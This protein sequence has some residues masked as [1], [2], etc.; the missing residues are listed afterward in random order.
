MQ[1]NVLNTLQLYKSRMFSDLV[2]TNKLS[3]SLMTRPHEISTIVSYLFGAYD[4]AGT[5]IDFLTGG[6]GKTI[7]IQNREFEWPV[8]IEADK[9]ITIRRA[10]VNG[11]EVSDANYATIF[12]GLNNTPI[13]L[14]LEEKWFGPGAILIFDD[15]SFKVRVAGEPEQDGN[16]FVYT[17]FMQDAQP[18]SYVPGHLLLPSRQVSREGTAYE[19]YSEEADI[20]NYSTPFKLRNCTTISRLTW[21]ITGDAYS[22]VMTIAMKDPK[23]GKTSFLW[24]PYQEWQGMRQW[25]CTLEKQMLYGLYN[26]NA[27]GTTN[28][29]GT[30][31]RPVFTGAG[32]L[33]Q[34]S[35]ANRR[36]YTML[37]AELLEDFL[38]DLSY[39]ILG[40]DNRKFV[41]LTGEMGMKEFDRVLKQKASGY[42]LIDTH[43]VSGSGQ[44]LTLGGQ[45]TTYRMLNGIE[46]TLRYCPMYDNLVDNRRLH[47][48]SGKPLE[49]YRMTFL[50]FGYR[51]GEPNI[52]KVIKKG[53]G[54]V[55]W[56]TGGSGGPQGFHTSKTSLA[57]NAKDGYAVHLLS[58][59]GI[60]IKD[61]TTCGEL[62]CDAEDLY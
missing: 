22:T 2:D 15:R 28:L 9:A 5:T 23:S 49:S 57:S 7:T 60:M 48:L 32:V 13:K 54:L 51:D 24:A 50:D 36:T 4:K 10:V 26:Q 59:W 40:M 47:P 3:N 21:D 18:E 37:T 11:V 41:A 29:T 39:N 43:F 25:Y 62:I 17:V 58:E 42:S 52:V 45:F 30:N 6:M 44:N 46:L 61:P 34:I 27:Q 38:Y 31:G 14:W 53:R 8:M 56:Y 35:P 19:E 12:A 1:N 16:E 55:M 33:Q 20:V